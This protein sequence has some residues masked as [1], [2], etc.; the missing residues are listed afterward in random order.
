MLWAFFGYLGVLILIGL[1]A[2]RYTSDLDDYLLADRKMGIWATS[3]SY[4]VTAYSGWLM[5]GFP[6]RAVT[7]GLAAL[8][9]GVACVVGDA[10]N[11]LLISRRLREETQE[12]NA[13]TVPEYL[14]RKFHRERSHSVRIAASLAVVT[15]ML[16]Y[17]WSQ[18]VAAGKAIAVSIPYL[19]YFW[20]TVVTTAVI[21]VYSP[22][23]R[24]W[25]ERNP[26]GRVV[27]ALDSQARSLQGVRKPVSFSS[28][29]PG[30]RLDGTLL[31]T[32]H[33]KE[34]PIMFGAG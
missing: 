12:L 31:K 15:F 32:P 27:D 30:E 21:M 29:A 20:A 33:G 34:L 7:R 25:R 4:E 6:G 5:L 3:V 22:S 18:M 28:P 11:W 14:D 10:L 19:D 13:L 24:S 8:W 9:V 16:I 17:L 1:V 23:R 2:R 26:G